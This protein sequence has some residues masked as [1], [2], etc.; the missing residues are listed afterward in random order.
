M[1]TAHVPSTLSRVLVGRGRASAGVSANATR[2]QPNLGMHLSANGLSLIKSFEGCLK[3]RPD[4]DLQAYRCPAGVW[5]IGH[6]CTV[7][8]H[9]GMVV[10]KDTAAKMF[11]RELGHFEIIVGRLVTVPLSQHEFDALVSFTYNCG[12]GALA[13]STLLRE[14][15]AGRQ[16]NVPGQLLRWTKGGGRV[17]NGL[18]RRRKAE[19]ALFLSGPALIEHEPSHYGPMPQA[20]EAVAGATAT[21]V[22]KSSRTFWGSMAA[23]LGLLGTKVL[24][25]FGILS[26]AAGQAETATSGLKPLTALLGQHAEGVL[27]IVGVVGIAMA[28]FARFDAATEGKPG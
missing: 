19:G 22:V 13:G 24:G 3:P 2:N 7:G 12:E 9:E 23:T 6:G 16:H 27:L 14:L 15:N 10:S 17:L 26:E 18:V 5:T 25:W 1:Q 20:V 8:V 28:V 21:S 11:A 4:G